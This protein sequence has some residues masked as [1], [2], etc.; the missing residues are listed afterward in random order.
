MKI[1]RKR[2]DLTIKTY[3]V[4]LILYDNRS[5]HKDAIVEK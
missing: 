3:R 4:E 5:I 1:F 2:K